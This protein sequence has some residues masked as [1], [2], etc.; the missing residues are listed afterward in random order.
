MNH[1]ITGGRARRRIWPQGVIVSV[2]L[3]VAACGSSGTSSSTT[4]TATPTSSS[5]PS[6]SSANNL[7]AEQ[8]YTECIREHGEP[9]FVGATNGPYSSNGVN[10]GSPTFKKAL[11]ACRPLRP[12]GPAHYSGGTGSN[13]GS[14]S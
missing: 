13:G 3:L 9:N 7:T 8:K 10:T 1:K 11:A 12:S 5:Q 14:A 4:S 6:Q 2:A